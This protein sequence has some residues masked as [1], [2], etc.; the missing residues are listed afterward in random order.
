MEAAFW[1]A[2]AAVAY[3]WLGY[4]LLLA[5]LAVLAPAPRRALKPWP[6]L[7]VVIAAYN[8]A[9]TIK[10]K[11]ASTLA[12]RYPRDCLEVI[13]VSDGSTDGTDDVVR[14]YPDSRIVLI[15]QEPRAGKSVALNRGVAAATGEILIFTDANALFAPDALPRLAA[16]FADPRV[17]L[18]SGQGLYSATGAADAGAVS[19]GYVR[20]EAWLRCGESALGALAN[21]DGAIYGLRRQLFEP[22][23]PAQVN[24]LLHPIQAALAGREARFDPYAFTIEPPSRDAGQEW[25]RHVRII[26]QGME[27]LATWAPRLLA[28]RRWRALWVLLSHRALRWATGPLLGVALALNV[29][30]AARSLVYAATLAAQLAF[31]GLALAGLAAERWGVRLG[32][33]SV[34]YYFCVVT[35]AGVAGFLRFL[36]GGADAIWAPGGQPVT[37]DR[38]A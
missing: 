6:R 10:A 35:T 1:L 20:Y 24:D 9:G 34:P 29:G 17:G 25:R 37:R 26:A 5:L 14:R 12:Q 23:G 28:A 36:R 11:I 3:T 13:V 19:N 15:R 4:P 31:Y 18:V 30:L 16:L 2:V 27:L 38:A 32:V 8:E 33:L 22:L 21:A 7:S